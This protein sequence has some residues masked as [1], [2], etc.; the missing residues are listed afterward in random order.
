MLIRAKL[1]EVH[2]EYAINYHDYTKEWRNYL[3]SLAWDSIHARAIIGNITVEEA[4]NEV[5]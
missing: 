2:K 3:E 4:V 1:V 5:L